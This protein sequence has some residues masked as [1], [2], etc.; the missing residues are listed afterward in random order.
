[1]QAGGRDM[2]DSADGGVGQLGDGADRLEGD[3]GDDR[4]DGGIGADTLYGG[5]GADSL[6]GGAG[7]DSLFGGEGADTLAVGAS[8]LGAYLPT[9]F[10]CLFAAGVYG[11]VEFWLAGTTDATANTTA[12]SGSCGP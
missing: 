11:L 3:A 12:G 6:A 1:M 2:V 8:L 10:V 5:D 7:T 4:L 9:T